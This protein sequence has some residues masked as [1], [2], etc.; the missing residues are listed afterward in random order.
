M[1]NE[2]SHYPPSPINDDDLLAHL[3]QDRKVFWTFMF[4]HVDSENGVVL[5]HNGEAINPPPFRMKLNSIS[6]FV[7]NKMYFSWYFDWYDP[8]EDEW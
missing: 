8:S 2:V 3:P 4:G 5:D 6:N 1:E 7:I